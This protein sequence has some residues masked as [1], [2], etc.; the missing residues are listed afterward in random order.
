MAQEQTQAR[1][2]IDRVSGDDA[3]DRTAPDP[4][5]SGRGDGTEAVDRR[6]SIDPARDVAT[7]VPDPLANPG[8]AGPAPD[9]LYGPDEMR[10][11]EP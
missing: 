6:V 11:V 5:A 3:P 10:P 7:G 8:A 4:E 2:V 1:P 9:V